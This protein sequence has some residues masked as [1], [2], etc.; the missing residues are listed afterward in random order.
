VLTA[1]SD[2]TVPNLLVQAVRLASRTRP[3]N[4]VVTNVPGPQIPL[5]LQGALMKTSY[6]VV[7]LFENLALS[8]GLF[9]YNGGLYWG[10][11]GEWEQLPDLHDMVTGIER[12]FEELRE[13]ARLT[14]QRAAAEESRKRSRPARAPER[15]RPLK[16]HA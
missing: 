14:A 8:I 13:L 11:N 4:L 3:Y 5:Y 15:T 7:P 2:W 9:S 10:V 16:K 6:P 1:I 12:S